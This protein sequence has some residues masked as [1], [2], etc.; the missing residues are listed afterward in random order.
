MERMRAAGSF[1]EGTNNPDFT[2]LT[3]KEIMN[4]CLIKVGEISSTRKDLLVLD[5]V[6]AHRRERNEAHIAPIC[7]EGSGVRST[8]TISFDFTI[9]T[10][11]VESTTKVNGTWI[12]ARVDVNLGTH[13]TT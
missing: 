3:N 12:C 2:V 6:L 5:H 8:S 9:T 11:N 4:S 13:T 10:D 1:L 7:T